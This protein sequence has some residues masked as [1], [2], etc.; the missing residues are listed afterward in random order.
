[1]NY[2]DLRHIADSYGLMFLAAIFVLL[3]GWTFR[4][5]A[6]RDH[7]RAATML[8]DEQERTDG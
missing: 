1:M 5:G 3:V 7:E 4:R 6:R 8:F 2:N